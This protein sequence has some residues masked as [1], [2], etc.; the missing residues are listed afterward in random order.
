M[1]HTQGAGQKQSTLSDKEI[2]EDILTSQKYISNYYYAPAVLESMDPNLR[3]MFQK[4]HN[5]T[6]SQAKQ[7]FDYLNSKGWYKPRQ[8]DPQAVNDLRNA[9]QESKQVLSSIVGETSD[10]GGKSQ[11]I[12]NP[13]VYSQGSSPNQPG[14]W[15]AQHTGWQSGQGGWYSQ[16][17]SQGF[18]TGTG[19]QAYMRTQQ[20]QTGQTGGWQPSYSQTPQWTGTQRGEGQSGMGPSS[21]AQWASWGGQPSWMQGG[22]GTSWQPGYS[23]A[24]QWTGT[25]RGE[26]Q[27]GMGPSSLAHWASWGG[28]PSWMQGSTPG[29]HNVTQT[30]LYSSYNTGLTSSGGQYHTGTGWQPAYSQTPQWTGTQAGEGQSGMGPSSL[31]QWARWGG[32][33]SWMQSGLGTQTQWR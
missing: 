10:M 25:Q 15:Q 8:A 22:T 9:A 26:G 11:M 20:Y 30:P 19:G 14:G 17:M 13:N 12:G 33:P 27:S 23:Q 16:P 28:Q 32:Q 31:A 7:V 18:Q 5:E 29:F 4:M 2:A 24:Q 6:Q 21:L 3:T 1:S